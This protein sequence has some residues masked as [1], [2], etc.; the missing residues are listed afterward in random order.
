MH[1]RWTQALAF[2]LITT[3]LLVQPAGLL[4]QS[5]PQYALVGATLNSGGGIVGGGSYQLAVAVGQP[6][7]IVNGGPYSLSLGLLT[8]PVLSK[9]Y[10]PLVSR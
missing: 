3:L 8:D 6:S 2:L 4:A 9:F 7:G 10:L 1:H 5:G